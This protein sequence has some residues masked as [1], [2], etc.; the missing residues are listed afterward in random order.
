MVCKCPF[1]F[2]EFE[3][4]KN[5]FLSSPSSKGSLHFR[6]INT[7]IKGKFESYRKSVQTNCSSAISSIVVGTKTRMLN[8]GEIME[9]KRKKNNQ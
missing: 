3:Y 1:A 6:T 9:V 2:F 5:V 7:I 4:N 8:C